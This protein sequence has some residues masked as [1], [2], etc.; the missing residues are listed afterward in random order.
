MS[1]P[2]SKL[3]FFWAGW[4]DSGGTRQEWRWSG[5]WN[6]PCLTLWK[7][8]GRLRKGERGGHKLKQKKQKPHALVATWA[9]THFLISV[10]G[11]QVLQRCRHQAFGNLTVQEGQWLSRLQIHA[12]LDLV[13]II[14]LFLLPL[15]PLAVLLCDACLNCF[16]GLAAEGAE[17]LWTWWYKQLCHLFILLLQSE[18]RA[19][20]VRK[21]WWGERR[22]TGGE[23]GPWWGIKNLPFR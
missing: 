2:E 21:A 12:G 5:R 8:V 18:R 4:R 23:R 19:S 13:L 22:G 15:G 9:S 10:V 16:E 6:F 20:K 14:A 11:V 17:A 1:V 3:I 7:S